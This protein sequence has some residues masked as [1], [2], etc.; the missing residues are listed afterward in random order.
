M[1]KTTS[2]FR[3]WFSHNLH[4]VSGGSL[5][6]GLYSSISGFENLFSELA[7]YGIALVSTFFMP[8]A[9]KQRRMLEIGN[10]RR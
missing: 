4:V 1:M 9:S 3:W 5:N 6:S 8:L 7:F 10:S 2:G